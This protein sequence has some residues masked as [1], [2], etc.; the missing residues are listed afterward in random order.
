MV[1]NG[2]GSGGGGAGGPSQR[3]SASQRRLTLAEALLAERYWALAEQHWLSSRS[4]PGR[5]VVKP[6]P[7]TPKLFDQTPDTPASLPSAAGAALRDPNPNP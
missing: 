4:Q 3:G 1:S 6:P 5:L 7:P 2:S